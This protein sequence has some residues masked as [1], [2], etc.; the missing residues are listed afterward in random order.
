MSFFWLMV[1]S[2]GCGDDNRVQFKIEF[3]V[4]R[5]I[6]VTNSN[7]EPSL[8]YFASGSGCLTCLGTV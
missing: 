5:G 4:S 8:Q 2:I 7:Q 3:V 6:V 1:V